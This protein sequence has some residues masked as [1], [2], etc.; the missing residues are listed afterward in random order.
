MT[1]IIM[2]IEIIDTKIMVDIRMKV[3]V[4]FV[5]MK[6]RFIFELQK[7]IYFK[8]SRVLTENSLNYLWVSVCKYFVL[9]KEL[10]CEISCFVAF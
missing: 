1:N 3:M 2:K 5:M 7:N 10:L 4:N 6:V 9:S 8:S